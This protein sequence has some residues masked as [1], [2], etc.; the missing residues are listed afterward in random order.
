MFSFSLNYP[1]TYYSIILHI[2]QISP[3]KWNYRQFNLLLS[4]FLQF[5]I[6]QFSYNA[7]FDFVNTY[8][9]SI[10]KDG[11]FMDIDFTNDN[12]TQFTVLP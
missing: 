10:V 1:T 7:I 12:N 9:S 8:N 5:S 6:S 3:E 2:L 11:K 4:F